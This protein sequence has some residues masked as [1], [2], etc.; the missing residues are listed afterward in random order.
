MELE[1]K[2]K[3]IEGDLFAPIQASTANETIVIAHVVNDKGAWGAG[4][5]VPLGRAYPK[6]KEDYHDWH[7]GKIPSLSLPATDPLFNLG[8][9][10]FSEVQKHQTPL[11]Y[12]AHMMAQTLG[13]RRPLFY[14]HLARCMDSVAHFALGYSN[15]KIV[16]PMFGSDLAG[17]NWSF[18][19]ELI[20]DCWLKRK[21]PV[22]IH[23]LP[24]RTPQGWTP[25]T[26]PGEP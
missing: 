25:P 4:F 20:T 8:V 23:Y 22:T 19:E 5:V 10:M 11:V 14:N 1:P 13:G 21:L 16:S 9:T 18:I 26:P 7:D 24:G 6:A 2:I 12:V 3:Y 17:G 15:P